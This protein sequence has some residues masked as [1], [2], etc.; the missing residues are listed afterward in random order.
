MLSS[1]F[2]L[3]VLMVVRTECRLPEAFTVAAI[4]DQD[5]DLTLDLMFVNAIKKVNRIPGFLPPGLALVPLIQRIPRD[6]SFLAERA[7]CQVLSKGVV[8]VFGPQSKINSEHVKSICDCSEIPYFET[9][10]GLPGTSQ[11]PHK[12]TTYGSVSLFP[13]FRSIGKILVDLMIRYGWTKVTLLYD[14]NLNLKLLQPILQHTAAA[15]SGFIINLKQLKPE[16]DE[17]Y[18]GVLKEIVANEG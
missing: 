1:G 7:T 8:A 6:N 11:N 17:D 12:K 4:F 2:S 9:S 15:S 10:L 14:T 3:L 13:D 16:E 5:T 18:R